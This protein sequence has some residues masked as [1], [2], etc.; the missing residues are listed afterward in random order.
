MFYRI[1]FR[2]LSVA[3]TLHKYSALK[4]LHGEKGMDV[5]KIL[6]VF[7][8]KQWYVNCHNISLKNWYKIIW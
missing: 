6:K 5:N 7:L 1:S 2:C 3:D 8:Q 4:L